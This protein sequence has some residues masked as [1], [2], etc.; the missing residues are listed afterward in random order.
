MFTLG[1]EGFMEEPLLRCPANVLGANAIVPRRPRPLAQ[2][3]IKD[4]CQLSQRESQGRIPY[5]KLGDFFNK[6]RKIHCFFKKS[7]C[8]VET[9]VV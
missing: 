9:L 7:Y 4:F 5:N 8:K 3:K 6:Y 2:S 1:G